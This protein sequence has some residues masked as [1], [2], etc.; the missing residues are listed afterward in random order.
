[1][2][3]EEKPFS[4]KAYAYWHK[5]VIIS[6]KK[7]SMFN[8]PAISYAE[9][10]ARKFEPLSA[11]LQMFDYQ[12]SHVKHLIRTAYFGVTCSHLDASDGKDNLT[13]NSQL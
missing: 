2:I 7:A 9:L 6:L 11:K 4:R 5:S 3:L 10:L 12:S 1:M 8:L 13:N